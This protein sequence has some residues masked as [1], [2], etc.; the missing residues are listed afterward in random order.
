[1]DTFDADE[2]SSRITKYK[3]EPLRRFQV[4]QD[5]LKKIPEEVELCVEEWQ[6]VLVDQNGRLLQ[7]VKLRDIVCWSGADERLSLLLST[8]DRVSLKVRRDDS[9]SQDTDGVCDRAMPNSTASL[10]P[11]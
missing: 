3:G 1:M 9:M 7:T 4:K 10:V 8:F 11:T 5:H 6:M 2:P